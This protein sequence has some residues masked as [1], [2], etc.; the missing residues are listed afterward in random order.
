MRFVSLSDPTDNVSFQ[1]ALS[2]GVPRD[3]T[4]LYVPEFIPRLSE[5]DI[6]ALIGAKPAEV[7]RI[8]LSQFVAD[9]MSAKDLAAIIDRAVTFETPIVEVGDKK[10]LEL[11]HGPTMAFKDVAARYLAAFM[12]HYNQQTGQRSTVLVAT[13]GDTGGAIAHGFADMIGVDVVVA[14]PKGR[15]SQLQQ[16][17]L[18]RVASNVY[19]VEVDGTFNDCLELTTAAFAEPELREGLGLTTANSISV[20]RLLPQTTYYAGLYGQLTDKTGRVVVPTGNLGNLTAGLIT[21][22]MGVPLPE[23]LA[24]NNSNDAL[25]RYLQTGRYTVLRTF[26]TMSNAMDV[27]DPKNQP[28]FN[29]LFG[30]DI[31]RMRAGVQAAYVSELETVATIVKVHEETGYLLDPHT[32]VA[33]Q[34]SNRVK[35]DRSDIIVSTAS[36]VKFAEEIAAKTGI[37]V[38]NDAE[39]R[40]LRKRPERQVEIENSAEDFRVVLETIAA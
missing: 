34:A 8:M 39:L 12:S 28:R 26:Q 27:N 38:N 18:R 22:A 2:N 10:V 9:E 40:E 36:P 20:G 24:A 33:W 3:D 14:Y 37:Q 11:F 6:D 35:S 1:E 5:D 13:S 21:Q 16:E 4:S 15:V 25:R 32:A 17:Q 23:F 19:P 29:W 7:G 31:D 30:G